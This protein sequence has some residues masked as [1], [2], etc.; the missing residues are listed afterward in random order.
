MFALKA[1]VAAAAVVPRA[2]PAQALEKIPTSTVFTFVLVDEPSMLNA[3]FEPFTVNLLNSWNAG[4][5]P[6]VR[7]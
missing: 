6:E 4:D 7:A 3:V 1:G 5:V 2:V